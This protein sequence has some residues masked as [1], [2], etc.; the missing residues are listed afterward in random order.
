MEIDAVCKGLPC[1]SRGQM[2]LVPRQKELSTSGAS[3]R[4][5]EVRGLRTPFLTEPPATSHHPRLPGEAPLRHIALGEALALGDGIKTL[6]STPPTF[7]GDSFPLWASG[8]SYHER[9]ASLI[10][11]GP[12]C[13][14]AL[15]TN[16]AAIPAAPSQTSL[17]PGQ[18]WEDL[19][20]LKGQVSDPN[21]S[22]S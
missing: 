17:I 19:E 1:A 11:K 16:A 3:L 13:L 10:S 15:L 22:K 9:L 8:S 5:A 7:L 2:E 14:P 18:G 21:S 4:S 6:L 12:I 20:I